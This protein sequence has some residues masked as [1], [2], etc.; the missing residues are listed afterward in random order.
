MGFVVAID[1]PAG[2][3]KG[4]IT[5]II[6]K[7]MKLNSIDTGAMYRCVT[8]ACL[9]NNI[10]IT[11]LD[12][13]KEVLNNINIELIKQNDNLVVKLN[14]E[15]VSK[16]IRENPV[17]Q[18]VAKVSSIKE[19]RDKLVELQRKMAESQ[20]VIME[21]RDI[22]TV[23]FPNADVK[24]YL[25]ADLEERAKRRFEQNKAKN[26]ECTFEDVLEDM[27]KRDEMDINKEYGALKKAD[28][29][30]LIDS[31]NLT[32]KEV[33]KKIEKLIKNK[34]KVNKLE[35]K[36]YWERPETKW[37]KFVRKVTKGFLRTLYK[38]AFR[39]EITG[40]ENKTKAGENGG[41]IICANH[42]NFLD[43]VAV[44]VFSKEKIRFIG[45]Y[46]LA[47]VGIIRWLAHLFDV[48]PIKRNTQDLEAM[49]RAL[50][51]LKNG[52]ILGIFP[53][54]TRR[55]MAKNQ[56]VKNGAA[57]MAIRAGVPVVPVG[58]SGSFKPFGKVRIKY[59][60]PLDMSKYKIKG[61][62][63]E[64]QEKA[65]KEIMDNIVKLTNE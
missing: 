12:S 60:E 16:E 4:T 44:V 45:K 23:V 29:A 18:N 19:V 49:K 35:P 7:K 22:T 14:G 48:I 47:R 21:G 41:F 65:T 53:E 58:I 32:Q 9:K 27:R 28:D 40:E 1:G 37:K 3:G 31:T 30:I 10:D 55:G 64:G 25:D 43:A 24:I 63:K 8:L 2:S 11:N 46:D 61:Q 38:I 51:A 20:D 6:A 34:K 36:I 13:V 50:K 39:M 33:V 56:K 59:G 15:D 62:E 42:V 17:N 54:G 26:I 5:S 52:E 57:F